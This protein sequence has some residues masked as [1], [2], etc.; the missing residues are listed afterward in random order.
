MLRKYIPESL[1]ANWWLALDFFFG[2]ACF[3]GRRD[4]VSERVYKRV[5]DVLSPLFG[6][7]ENTSTYQRERSS[8]WEN[9]RRELEMRIG[10][11]KVGKGR[12]VEMILSTLDFIGH[13]PSLNIVGY[14]VQKIRSGEIKEHYDELQRDIVQVGPKIAA[15]Y[16]RDVV[17]LYQL[18]N[19]VPEE[20]AFCLQPIDVWVR[21]LV[22]KIGMVDNEAS[23]DE[24]REAI[25]TLCRDYKVSPTQFNQGA[26]YLGY[27]AFDLLFEMLLIKAGVTS[28]SGQVA[29]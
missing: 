9:I 1:L 24:V 19:L 7:T 8:G 25:I 11:G 6:G 12:D 26:W 18:E 14:S 5:V 27:F 13:L 10:K 22:K 15:F 16:L 29:C 17:S 21:K 3:Q 2:R 28:N 23:D 4:N 20:F